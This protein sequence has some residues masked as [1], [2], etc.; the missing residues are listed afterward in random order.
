[1]LRDTLSI[2]YVA[3]VLQEVYLSKVTCASVFVCVCLFVCECVCVYVCLFVCL[4]V[5]ACLCVCVC[6]CL[7]ICVCT[8]AQFASRWNLK[9][10]PSTITSK[11]TS[12]LLQTDLTKIPFTPGKA[13]PTLSSLCD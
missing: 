5:F 6:I 7:C 10:T 11:C 12:G 2:G 1:M 13:H 3:S 8:I 4:C 9:C